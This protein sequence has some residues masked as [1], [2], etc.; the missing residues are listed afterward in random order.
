M[1]KKNQNII[2]L[3][4]LFLSM[5]IISNY[6][7]LLIVFN[8]FLIKFHLFSFCLIF[9][10]FIFYKKFSFIHLKITF[11][12]LIILLLGNATVAWDGWAVWTFKA[13]RIYFDQSL[14]GALK[15]NYAIFQH[16]DYPLLA[17]SLAA[18]FAVFFDS[19]NEI[20]PKIGFLFIA[21]PPLIM[22]LKI[23]NNN[24]LNFI[25]VCISLYIINSYFINGYLDGLISI[26]FVFCAYLLFN[27]FIELEIDNLKVLNL[28]FF[29]MILS[30]LKNEGL[31]IIL[32]LF[33]SIMLLNFLDRKFFSNIKLKMFM[34]L[35]LVP[36]L[37]WRYLTFKNNI[38][39]YHFQENIAARIGTAENNVT[40][41]AYQY[42]FDRLLSIDT[43]RIFFGYLITS[44]SLILS[45]IFFSIS[46]YIFKNKKI[47]LYVISITLIY[48]VCYL[49]VSMM[50][51][52][53]YQWGLSAGIHRVLFMPLSYLFIFF[54]LYQYYKDRISIRRQQKQNS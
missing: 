35:S 15:D 22:S 33:F 10:F 21:F 11:I 27:I 29:L 9:F 54:C 50:A 41:N 45:I 3:I 14:F 39:P 7:S 49:T 43:Y 31:V 40:T 36:I 18:S 51:S 17:P 12:V 52:M 5:L 30:L 38:V 28:F 24:R 44:Y 2:E 20:F 26:Y 13:K 6:L 25:F 42:F 23:F 32:T 4:V 19:W 16:N 34:L 46:C 1:L 8:S 48:T 53:D 37:Y 47:T